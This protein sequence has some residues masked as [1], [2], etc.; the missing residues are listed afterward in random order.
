MIG[1]RIPG[2]N[3]WLLQVDGNLFFENSFIDGRLTLTRARVTG[4]LRLSGVTLTAPEIAEEPDSSRATGVWALW[5]GGLV[6]EGGVFARHGF[7][8]TGGLRLVGAQFNGGLFME[9]ARIG[10][11]GGDS[12][13]GDDLSASTMILSDG[14]TATGAVRLAGASVRSR[15]SLA[16]AVLGGADVALEAVRLQAGDLELTPAAAVKGSVDLQGAKVAV[17]HD[18]EHSWPAD[19]RIDGFEYTAIHAA[20]DRPDSVAG[21]LGW[22]ARLPGYAPQPYEQLAGWYRRIG[23]DGDA[24]RVLLEK[25]RRRRRT[26]HPV[27]QI[28][29]RVLDVTV[30]YGYRPWQVGLWLLGLALVGTTVFGLQDP[31]ATQPEQSQ[32]FD[33]LVYTLDL[34]IPI[35]GFGMRAAWYWTGATQYLTYALIAAGWLLTTA[36][37]AGVTRSLNRA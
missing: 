30:G 17:L 32:P 23:H 36:V 2:L 24:R 1:C 7:T 13:T 16:G 35:G 3:G 34:L 4:E 28:W 10:N 22:I 20:P 9:G 26:L 21:R 29:G 25:Q 18:N 19:S 37:V 12:F 11:P 14:F 15:L 5:A 31:R 6:M 33:P 8:A 27:A